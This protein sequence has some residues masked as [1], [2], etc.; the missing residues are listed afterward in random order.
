KRLSADSGLTQTG[1]LIGTP[2]YMAPEQ[3][4]SKHG[5]ITTATDVYGLG[6][7]FYALLTGRAPFRADTPLETM[8]QVKDRDPDAPRRLNPLVPRDLETICLKCLAKEPGQRYA[9]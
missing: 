3:A 1:Q 6:A 9:S 8:T 2:S 5:A 7:V 4:T